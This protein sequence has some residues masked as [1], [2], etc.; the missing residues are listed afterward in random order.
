[1]SATEAHN[2]IQVIRSQPKGFW[3]K[4]AHHY[5]N[6]ANWLEQT[7]EKQSFGMRY[8]P[9]QTVEDSMLKGQS[10]YFEIK[11]A[12]D[13]KP[14][15]WRHSAWGPINIDAFNPEA[16]ELSTLTHALPWLQI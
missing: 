14:E 11:A 8:L 9:D 15:D 10:A 6:L 3:G 7:L 4:H 5:W 16:W 12:V 1:L 2:V 13:E